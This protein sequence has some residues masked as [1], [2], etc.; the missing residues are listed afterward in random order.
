MELVRLAGCR[1]SVAGEEHF[2]DKNLARLDVSPALL[3]RDFLQFRSGGCLENNISGT[4][5]VG[6]VGVKLK[7]DTVLSGL[8][9]GNPFRSLTYFIHIALNG[10]ESDSATFASDLQSGRLR[11]LRR[12]RTVLGDLERLQS[13]SRVECQRRGSRGSVLVRLDR[14]GDLS[15][16]SSAE[17]RDRVPSVCLRHLCRPVSV[18]GDENFL[19]ASVGVKLQLL[20]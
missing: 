8:G 9:H 11:L 13:E 5:S 14:D 18:G 20:G 2:L 10:R 15:V 1:K 17:S 7:D 6:P 4:V 12:N 19:L 3:Q 16:G